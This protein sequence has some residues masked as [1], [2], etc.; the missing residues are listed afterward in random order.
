MICVSAVQM[1]CYLRLIVFFVFN[2]AK[3]L[4]R[5]QFF[6]SVRTVQCLNFCVFK[7]WVVMSDVGLTAHVVL[8]KVRMQKNI[9][10]KKWGHKIIVSKEWQYR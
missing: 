1:R 6:E 3:R 7:G 9:Y 8:Q 5:A 2:S 10:I 4:I